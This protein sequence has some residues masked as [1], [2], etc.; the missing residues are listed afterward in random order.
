MLPLTNAANL[1]VFTG[2][3]PVTQLGAKTLVQMLT[4]TAANATGTGKF[5]VCIN[6]IMPGV[7]TS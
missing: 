6:Y 5:A 2:P 1:R 4:N 3:F 7:A